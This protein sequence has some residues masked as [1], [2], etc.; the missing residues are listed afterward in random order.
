MKT[1][2]L[3]MVV[4][5]SSLLPTPE[6]I[7]KELDHLIYNFLWKDKDKVSRKSPINNYEGGGIKMVDNESLKKNLW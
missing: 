6:H 5:M 4:Y 7:I 1:L 2:L 3:L